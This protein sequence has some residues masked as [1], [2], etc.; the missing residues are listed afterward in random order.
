MVGAE[1][2]KARDCLRV[3][4]MAL[5]LGLPWQWMMKN[6]LRRNN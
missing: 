5:Q 1:L 4:D 2:K 6:I 3:A